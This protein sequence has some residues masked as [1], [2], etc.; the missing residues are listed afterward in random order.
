MRYEKGRKEATRQRIIDVAMARFRNDG[1]AGTGL[2]SIMADAGLTNG[3]FYPHFASKT[4]LVR[5]AVVEAIAQQADQLRR[6]ADAGGVDTVIESYLSQ[7][8]R[9][10][11]AS[12][13][14]LAALLPELARQ[15]PDAH[16]TYAEPF[17]DAL[18][19]MEQALPE[20]LENRE[21]AA[22]G[23]L[24]I[25]IGTLQ[26]SRALAGTQL[27]D[28]ILAAGADA[29]RAMTPNAATG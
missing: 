18:H 10:N 14:P 15:A 9:D 7:E 12:G 25:L 26:L 13:C 4:S 2:A 27:S 28:R 1:I 22:I 29:A 24:A 8:H 3:A 23:L 21:S 20:D 17:E 6:L 5:E 19:V 11:P 16:A